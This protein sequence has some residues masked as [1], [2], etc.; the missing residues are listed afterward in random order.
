MSYENP[1]KLQG[2]TAHHVAALIALGALLFLVAVE[3]G[4]R[5]LKIDI[6]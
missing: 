5:G 3:R 4:F 1:F 2:M 6:S